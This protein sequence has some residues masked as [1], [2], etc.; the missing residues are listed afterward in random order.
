MASSSLIE[1]FLEILVPEPHPRTVAS[2]ALEMGHGELWD[3]KHFYFISFVFWWYQ[4]LNSG[5]HA[6]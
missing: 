6:C 2:E 3:F 4:G 5:P 1:N